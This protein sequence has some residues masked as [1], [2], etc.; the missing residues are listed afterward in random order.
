[1][2]T[3]RHVSED[4]TFP[5]SQQ[6]RGLSG[7]MVNSWKSSVAAVSGGGLVLSHLY[8]DSNSMVLLLG[9]QLTYVLNQGV[10][11]LHKR[12]KKCLF[13]WLFFPPRQA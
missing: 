6:R 5:P 12:R 10:E 8:H 3:S 1:M 9:G 4:S 7:G 13:L 11:T 2:L